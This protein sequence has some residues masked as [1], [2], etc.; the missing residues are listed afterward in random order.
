MTPRADQFKQILLARRI[1]TAQTR[2]RPG[3]STAV[4]DTC[5]SN[6]GPGH[7]EKGHFSVGFDRYLPWI[8]LHTG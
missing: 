4:T 7:H 5:K 1:E 2:H 8:A 6:V 3:F